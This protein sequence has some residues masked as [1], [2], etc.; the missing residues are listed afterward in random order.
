MNK[1]FNKKQSD[2]VFVL[3]KKYIISFAV[4]F[5]LIVTCFIIKLNND[6][7]EEVTLFYSA[8]NQGTVATKGIKPMDGIMVGKSMSS[9]KYSVDKTK[10]AVLMS[11]N[12]NYSLYYTDGKKLSLISDSSTNNYVISLDGKKTAY[13]DSYDN[14]SIFDSD[15]NKSVLIDTQVGRFALSPSGSAVVYTKTMESA[16]KLYLYSKNKITEIGEGY[17]PLAVSD[18][19]DYIY[20]LGCDNSLCVLDKNGNMKSKIC[21]SVAT[22]SF[23]FSLDMSS[24]VFCDGNY[25][26]ISNFGKSRVRLT[27]NSSTPIEKNNVNASCDS[28]QLTKVYQSLI[29]RFYISDNANNTKSMFYINDDCSRIDIA[30]N[31]KKY[32]ITEKDSIV[33]L[34]DSSNIYRFYKGKNSLIVSAVSDMVADKKGKYIY[35]VDASSHLSAA[36]KDNRVPLSDN[37]KNI[38]I[39][40]DDLLL[41]VQNDG[42]L[43]CVKKDN[44]IHLIDENVYGCICNKKS[45]FYIKNYSSQTGNFELYGSDSND[46][47]E[48]IFDNISNI[49]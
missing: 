29:E 32:V 42:K 7:S 5:I 3:K 9:A 11:V 22:D 24:V 44:D 19:L 36:V 20:V 39:T 48:K 6:K 1:I 27:Q 23:C 43:C 49:I 34:D 41:F 26:Y 35:Y 45:S 28:Q 47:F 31:V 8:N 21:S 13:C 37:V 4:I 17:I 18:D 38:Y 16:E 33:Y 10:A 15:K 14:F 30:D 46:S 40:N 12:S 2:R 25:T